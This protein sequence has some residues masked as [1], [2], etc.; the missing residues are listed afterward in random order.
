MIGDIRQNGAC[1]LDGDGVAG[2]DVSAFVDH[3]LDHLERRRIANVIGVGLERQAKHRH[4]L[5]FDHPQSFED[6]GDE[7]LDALFVDALGGFEDVEVHADRAGEMHEGLQVLR[8]AEATEAQAGTQELAADA[9]VQTHRVGHFLDVGADA[10]AEIGDDVG[11]ADF[12]RE[13]RVGS[14][15]DQLGAVDGGDQ[16]L[17]GV[18]PRGQT[19][20]WTGQWKVR[21]RIGR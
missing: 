18:E 14:V 8:E 15:L 11:V 17:R 6:F 19:P 10:F 9:G 5:A 12:Q 7:A 16:K 4:P 3:G 13:E 20:L 2:V 1:T 21:S